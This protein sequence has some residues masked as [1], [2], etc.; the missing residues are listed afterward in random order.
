MT[1]VELLLAAVCDVAAGDPRWFPHPV[2]GMGAVVAWVDHRIRRLCHSDHALQIAGVCLAL[3][4]PAAV[5]AAAT[6]VIAQATGGAPLF[7]QLVGVGLAYTTLAGRDLFDH[8]QAVLHELSA[9]NLAG[10]REAVGRI[11]GRDSAGLTEPAFARTKKKT[12]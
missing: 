7:G 11:V 4:L 8:V 12:K 3:G 5:Y 10:A 1:G 6:W 9:G 2:K